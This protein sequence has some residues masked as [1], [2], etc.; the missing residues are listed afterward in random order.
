MLQRLVTGAGTHLQAKQTAF[1]EKRL[2]TRTMAPA[3][4]Y[5]HLLLRLASL[6]YNNTTKEF[7]P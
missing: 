7:N 3:Q 5:A 2:D 6:R 1:D 4:S